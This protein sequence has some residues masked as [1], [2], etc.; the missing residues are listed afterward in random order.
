MHTVGTDVK[1]KRAAQG[2]ATREALLAAAR[3]LFGTQ[4][5]A[6]TSTEEVVARAG[7]TKGALYHHFADKEDL[8]RA[9][10]EQVQREVSERAAEQFLGPDAWESLVNGCVLWVAAHQD[11][12]IRRISLADAQ[13]VLGVEEARAIETRFSAVTIRGALR[14]AMRA[15]VI[16]GFPL[17]PLSLMLTGALGEACLFVAAADDA[18]HAQREVEQIVERLLGGLRSETAAP[19][20]TS[21]PATT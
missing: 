20:S 3:D 5:Y 19:G 21:V 14:K 4:G 2:R 8:F 18:G 7:V 10:Y 9:V 13:S 6:D 1:G 15:G 11:P 16:E 17:R 12:V